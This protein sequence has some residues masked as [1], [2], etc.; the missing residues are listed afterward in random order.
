MILQH[1]GLPA[2]RPGPHPMRSFAQSAFVDEDDG[3]PLAERFFLICGQRTSSTAGS[4]P[5]RAPAP[6]RWTLAAPAE[7]AQDAPDVGLVVAHP[8]LVLDQLAHPAR[9]P[10]PAGI[11]ERLGTALERLLDLAQLARAEFGLAPGPAGLLKPR[12]PDWTS[13]RAQRITD[14]RWTPSR[15][16]TSLWLMPC[17]SNSA[18]AIRR[19][20]SPAKSRRTPAGLPMSTSLAYVS[21]LYKTQ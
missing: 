15:R 16:A 19:C 2:R 8:A 9:G 3:A 6:A 10:Q 5:R 21:I 12:R 1:R 7:L 11:S 18:A 20:S 4:P 17:L 13:S 14:C